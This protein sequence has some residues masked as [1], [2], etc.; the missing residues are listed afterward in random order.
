MN[1]AIE[2]VRGW[3]HV[4]KVQRRFRGNPGAAR[5][6]RSSLNNC[7]KEQIG[8]IVV[9]RPQCNPGVPRVEIEKKPSDKWGERF[10][11]SLDPAAQS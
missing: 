9:R 5:A 4:S 2:G 8:A 6:T 10:L 11:L 1:V 7:F 3:R